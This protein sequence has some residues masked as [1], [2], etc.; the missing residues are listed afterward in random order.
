MCALIR[1]E[2]N[3]DLT[4]YPHQFQDK[5]VTKASHASQPESQNSLHKKPDEHS[6][7]FVSTTERE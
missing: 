7:Y 4:I 2:W 3:I 6:H 5:Q 1:I